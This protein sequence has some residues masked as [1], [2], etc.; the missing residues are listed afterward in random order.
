M[1]S[2]HFPQQLASP[3]AAPAAHLLPDGEHS[4]GASVK[5]LICIS[6]VMHPRFSVVSGFDSVRRVGFSQTEY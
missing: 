1:L 5:W 2:A 6:E 3:A 4:K